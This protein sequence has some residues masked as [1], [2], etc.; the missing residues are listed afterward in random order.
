[1]KSGN[2]QQ[3]DDHLKRYFV[4]YLPIPS[5][6]KPF[7]RILVF[8]AIVFSALAGIGIASQQKSAGPGEWN[9]QVP[10][11]LSGVM[12]MDPY[13]ILQRSDVAEGEAAS[14]LLVL[15]GKHSADSAANSFVGKSVSVTGFAIKRGG[16]LMLEIKGEQSISL[17]SQDAEEAVLPSISTE[18]EVTLAGE[19]MDSKCFL[20]VMNPGKG[21]TH[22]ACAELCL[23][24]GIP[25]MLAVRD[26][27][28]RKF[29]YLLKTADGGSASTLVS[30][31]AAEAVEITGQ[32][33]RQGDLLFIRIAEN[34]I[35]QL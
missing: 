10:V 35:T 4:G 18:G 16:W 32:L 22:K 30:R 17:N 23:L 9:T 26:A 11:T 5:G 2:D 29:G 8:F 19:I 15:Q 27:E 28:G 6:L 7:Y 25:P 13:P 20:G 1:M 3:N 14:V 33:E 12:T 31:R 24:G 21:P 34:R